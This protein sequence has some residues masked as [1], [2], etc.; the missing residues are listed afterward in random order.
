MLIHYR[1][2]LLTALK[3]VE[4][5]L[6]L[7]LWHLLLALVAVVPAY[8]WWSR[9]LGAS[10][11]AATLLK[12]FNF[13]VLGD[14]MKYDEVGGV[15]LLTGSVAALMVV[16]LAAS[17]FIMG[18]I[19]KV[20]A[21]HHESRGLIRLF[22]DGGRD[23]YWR[24]VRLLLLAG[25]CVLVS[26]V[27]VAMVMA[28]IAVPAGYSDWEGADYLW[29]LASLLVM[30]V[31]AGFFLLA[32]DYARVRVALDD[33]RSMV[34]A[35]IRAIGFVLSHAVTAYGLALLMVIGLAVLLAGYVTYETVSPVAASWGAIALLFVIQQAVALG[36]TTLRVALIDAELRYA[37]RLQPR[38]VASSAAAEAPDLPAPLP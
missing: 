13:A 10:P 15:T 30:A 5:I 21:A 31:V 16:S 24:Y 34:R 28:W 1:D 18:G 33:S 11:E 27:I 4:L 9:T 19:L 6:L 12:G 35:Y 25:V 7:W 2:S 17:S 29:A 38:A 36:Y 37:E 26:G 22:F 20:L 32:L 3:S 8:G 23:C 14:V